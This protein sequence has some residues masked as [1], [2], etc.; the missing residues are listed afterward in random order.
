VY[1][2]LHI[3]MSILFLLYL[4]S[5]LLCFVLCHSIPFRSVQVRHSILF[6]Y[7]IPFRS[8]HCTFFYSIIL[9]YSVMF[10]SV[11]FYSIL[12]NPLTY[13]RVRVWEYNRQL[14]T[15]TLKLRIFLVLCK[16]RR[17]TPS[18]IHRCQFVYN[19]YYK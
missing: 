1:Y 16:F 9:F 13:D 12:S 7:S 17:H 3:I 6:Y 15:W 11:L 4:N 18:L 8:F 2:S 19:W 14:M 10:C 5:V